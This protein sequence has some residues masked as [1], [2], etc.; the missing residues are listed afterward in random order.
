M[1]AIAQLFWRGPV[2]LALLA[3]LGIGMPA[4][5]PAGAAQAAPAVTAAQARIL[6]HAGGGGR[7]FAAWKEADGSPLKGWVAAG[8]LLLGD[9]TNQGVIVP[10]YAPGKHGV[11]NY[12]LEARLRVSGPV[13]PTLSPP[14][15]VGLTART[16]YYANYALG[17]AGTPEIW[18]ILG[19]GRLAAKTFVVFDP[20]VWHTYRLEVVGTHLV[21]LIDGVPILRVDDP[22]WTDGGQAG[23]YVSRTHATVSSFTIT[24]LDAVTPA[25]GP[26]CRASCA[27]GTVLYRSHWGAGPSGLLDWSASSAY[28]EWTQHGGALISK[29][30]N[31]QTIRPDFA[32][33]DW[34]IADYAVEARIR[35]RQP[36]PPPVSYPPVFS[37]VARGGY[38][39]WATYSIG[40]AGNPDLWANHYADAHL[41]GKLFL[42]FDPTAWHTY[43]IEVVG[44]AIR[45]LID[46]VVVLRASNARWTD[47]GFAA[48]DEGGAHLVVSSFTIVALSQPTNPPVPGCIPHC[49][50]GTVLYQSNLMHGLHSLLDWSPS[51]RSGWMLQNGTLVSDFTGPLLRPDFAPGDWGIADYA[52]E[53]RIRFLKAA[54]TG[55]DY[56]P[57]YGIVDRG[58]YGYWGVYAAPPTA[59][60]GGYTE[61][62]SVR[63]YN[64]LAEKDTPGFTPYQWHTYRVEVQGA[65]IRFLIDGSLVLTAQDTRWKD[66]GITGFYAERGRIA[67][68]SFTVTAL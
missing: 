28:A 68:R 57:N 36:I 32:P 41:A 63:G 58:G 39:Y 3:T 4:R 5:P 40:G 20:T 61:L 2:A 60:T 42:D 50:A 67:V 10:P 14:A 35:V 65:S 18:S 38:G 23:V 25:P 27:P 66:G 13:S 34:K 19:Y 8:G 6:Y 31:G 43:R 17:G 48:L 53:A 55:T 9:G 51:Q 46:G 30:L 49:A 45:Y 1:T 7:S 44:Q 22:R 15:I 64:R 47:G 54:P 59:P 56:P 24:A 52:A 16:N 11:T 37:V 33:G 26:S 62:W 12:A 29:G 21:Y